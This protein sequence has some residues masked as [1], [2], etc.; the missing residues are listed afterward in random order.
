MSS[1]IHLVN[2]LSNW[3]H[4][5][6]THTIDRKSN[7]LPDED[8]TIL[9]KNRFQTKYLSRKCN[10]ICIARVFALVFFYLRFW[11]KNFFLFFLCVLRVLSAFVMYV[12][13]SLWVELNIHFSMLFCWFTTVIWQLVAVCRKHRT[14]ALAVSIK[15]ALHRQ[16]GRQYKFENRH[17][18][19]ME[20]K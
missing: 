18:C 20:K 13:L 8:L 2:W 1:L 6:T 5:T 11:N 15:I 12:I 7:R 17:G 3:K 14:L 4:L 10:L 16:D 9:I 19:Y